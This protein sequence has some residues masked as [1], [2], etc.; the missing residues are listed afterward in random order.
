M[1]IAYLVV[2]PALSVF[3]MD[4]VVTSDENLAGMALKASWYEHLRSG[5]TLVIP[6]D[7]G[8]IHVSV[9]E[10]KNGEL[11]QLSV[12]CR[13]VRGAVRWIGF[14][15]TGE[16][17]VDRRHQKLYLRMRNARVWNYDVKS[18]LERAQIAERVWTISLALRP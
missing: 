17:L 10:V 14:G 1:R 11:R 15:Y 7:H 5:K 4:S 13:D 9:S 18:G 6:G 8:D 16:L 2:A 12:V 3:A